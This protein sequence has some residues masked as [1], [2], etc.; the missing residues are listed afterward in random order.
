MKTT[1]TRTLNI[2]YLCSNTFEAHSQQSTDTLLQFEEY[3]DFTQIKIYVDKPYN[4]TQP[5]VMGT[6]IKCHFMSCDPESII[7]SLDS[8]LM[9]I[10]NYVS[11]ISHSIINSVEDIVTQIVELKHKCEI[12]SAQYDR[13]S[14]YY[15]IKIDGEWIYENRGKATTGQLDYADVV[16][17]GGDGLIDLIA[18]NIDLR[19]EFWKLASV[20]LS[21]WLEKM[22][23]KM[24]HNDKLDEVSADFPHMVIVE[25]VELL[26]KANYIGGG[27]SRLKLE[28]TLIDLFGLKKEKYNKTKSDFM[29]RSQHKFKNLEYL[30]DE[31]RQQ[32]TRTT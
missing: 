8:M 16:G 9:A 17:L 2:T 21:Y 11:R 18:Y 14:L 10:D 31:H 12:R 23:L 27:G 13:Q 28:K 30:I 15:K 6:V 29:R 1:K 4:K 5:N 32:I 7:S 25:F 24:F 3:L 22:T 26:A 19:G 20:R